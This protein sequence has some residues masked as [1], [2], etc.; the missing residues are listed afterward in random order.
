MSC[1]IGTDS[2]GGWVDLAANPLTLEQLEEAFSHSIVVAVAAA[3]H[4]TAQIMI[5]QKSLPVMPGE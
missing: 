5:P 1:D 3:T 4:A 2:L